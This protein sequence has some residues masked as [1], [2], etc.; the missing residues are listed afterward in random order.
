MDYLKESDQVAVTQI[1]TAYVFCLFVA[2]LSVLNAFLH[3]N[4][5]VI[6]GGSSIVAIAAVTG[7]VCLTRRMFASLKV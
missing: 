6:V 2:G 1:A 7:I 4:S 3:S 5:L